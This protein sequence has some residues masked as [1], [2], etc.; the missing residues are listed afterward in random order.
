MSCIN[1]T[2]VCQRPCCLILTQQEILLE[3]P[4]DRAIHFFRPYC[5][6]SEIVA[7][8][9]Q[10]HVGWFGRFVSTPAIVTQYAQ[11][12]QNASS[13]FAH[14]KCAIANRCVESCY[15]TQTDWNGLTLSWR[16]P[17]TSEDGNAL[18]ILTICSLVCCFAVDVR[19][20][21]SKVAKWRNWYRRLRTCEGLM[22]RET[23]AFSMS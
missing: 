12:F 7:E 23:S 21:P 14:Q 1:L 16:P 6:S 17:W 2:Y 4:A 20:H 3:P 13:N 15:I 19:H 9:Q 11:A 18:L 10:A 22:Q 8:F 5:S